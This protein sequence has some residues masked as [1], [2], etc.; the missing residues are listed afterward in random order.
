MTHSIFHAQ[1]SVRRFGGR[2]EDY[3]SIHAWIDGSKEMFCDFRHRALRH[4][5]NFAS[6]LRKSRWT[7]A[8]VLSRRLF[9]A[10]TPVTLY[11]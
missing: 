7:K 6:V 5:G 11:L 9:V 8:E 4:L 2:I 1:S 10:S 3:F